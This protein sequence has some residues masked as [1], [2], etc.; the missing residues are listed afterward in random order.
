MLPGLRRPR[1]GLEWVTGDASDNPYPSTTRAP[2]RRS[3][4]FMTSSGI[5]A[6]PELQ[7]SMEPT[8]YSSALG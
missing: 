7:N 8:P 6:P 3:K 1:T 4:A 2:N 5:A